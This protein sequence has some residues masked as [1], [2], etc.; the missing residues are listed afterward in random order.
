MK[1]QKNGRNYWETNVPPEGRVI[2]R[3]IK[4]FWRMWARFFLLTMTPKWTFSFL[5]VFLVYYPPCDGVGKIIRSMWKLKSDGKTRVLKNDTACET[6]SWTLLALKEEPENGVF[7]E[8]KCSKAYKSINFLTVVNH[9][10]TS[11]IYGKEYT[12][13][14]IEHMFS[15]AVLFLNSL[16]E[17]VAF[18][19]VGPSDLYAHVP[20]NNVES[21]KVSFRPYGRIINW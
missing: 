8:L 1:G 11:K 6:K 10:I 18:M 4:V 16:A 3:G 21:K 5:K 15:S 20:W 13:S 17:E 7:L 19:N 2:S 9:E 14:N 12:K